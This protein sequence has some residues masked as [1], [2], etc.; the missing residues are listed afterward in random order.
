MT[1]GLFQFNSSI[2]NE[3]LNFVISTFDLIYLDGPK[4]SA[5]SE[6][7]GKIIPQLSENN[8]V[9]QLIDYLKLELIILYFRLNSQ[10]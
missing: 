5:K 2:I 1:Q 4:G 8:L 6:T 3:I 7:I 10:Y 9:F